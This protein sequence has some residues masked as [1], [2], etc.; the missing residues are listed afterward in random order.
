[1]M[2]RDITFT[3]EPTLTI[4]IVLILAASNA[5]ALGAV[6]TGSMNAYEQAIVGGKTRSKGLT[7]KV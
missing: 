4:A 3:S 1:M 7:H 6:E 5:I 2:R